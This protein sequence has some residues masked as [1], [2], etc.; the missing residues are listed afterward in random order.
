MKPYSKEIID[1]LVKIRN[2]G[3]CDYTVERAY[4]MFCNIRHLLSEP[5]SRVIAVAFSH[6]MTIEG[7]DELVSVCKEIENR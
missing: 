1:E 6:K 7:A 2:K 4:R 3:H 5:D